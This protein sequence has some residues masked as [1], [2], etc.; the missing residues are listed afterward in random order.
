MELSYD[1]NNHFISD[2]KMKV[3]K[4]SF[5][6]DLQETLWKSQ[7]G[8]PKWAPINRRRQD[9]IDTVSIYDAVR[10]LQKKT[11]LTH[12]QR[13]KEINIVRS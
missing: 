5:P 11:E 7:V 8:T 1:S 13:F 4:A 2:S 12:W 10:E 9:Y 3:S 6:Q